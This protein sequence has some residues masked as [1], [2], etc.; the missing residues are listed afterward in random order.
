MKQF[1][2]VAMFIS[3]FA[4]SGCAEM[5][6]PPLE[7]SPL[8]MLSLDYQW[9]KGGYD[10]I[11]IGDLTIENENPFDVKDIEIICTH[12]DK[13]GTKMDSNVRKVYETVK[14]KSKKA[15]K[16]FNMGFIHLK[17]DSTTCQVT[18]ARRGRDSVGKSSR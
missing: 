7:T 17:V 13:N 12:F 8:A 15:F 4:V 16:D 9:E 6:P 11:M 3:L 10:N 5:Q 18:N 1:L 14:A 2:L